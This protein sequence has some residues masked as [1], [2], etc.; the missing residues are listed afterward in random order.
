MAVALIPARKGSKRVKDKNIRELA[1]VPLLAYSIYSAIE[2]P[3]IT[4]VYVSTDS[5]KYTEIANGY[6]AKVIWRPPELAGDDVADSPVIAHALRQMPATDMLVYL[7]PTT[8]LRSSEIMREAISSFGEAIS[9]FDFLRDVKNGPT[10]LR[11]VEL[12]SESAYKY[13]WMIGDFLMPLHERY[14]MEQTG[15]PNQNFPPTYRPNGYIDIVQ[16]SYIV[17]TGHAWG[18]N[19]YGY[20]TPPV[21]EVDTERDLKMLEY[22]IAIK[23]GGED[24]IFKP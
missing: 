6:G 22:E 5:L 8:P 2:C 1:G 15:G 16:P 20:L 4:A 24:V 11:S 17:E 3:D 9:S 14:S 21:I 7:R 23:G 13:Y 10:S 12:M 18:N 19:V